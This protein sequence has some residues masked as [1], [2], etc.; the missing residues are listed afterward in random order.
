MS[1]GFGRGDM[2]CLRRDCPHAKYDVYKLVKI[3]KIS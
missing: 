3:G 2:C 1:S